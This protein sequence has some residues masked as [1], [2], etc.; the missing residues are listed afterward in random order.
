MRKLIFI[1]FVVVSIQLN[2]QELLPTKLNSGGSYFENTSGSLEVSVGEIYANLELK[3]GESLST[4][5]LQPLEKII[6]DAKCVNVNIITVMPNPV[7]NF[8]EIQSASI[9]I[10]K[11]EIIN[12][13]GNV[14][15]NQSFTNNLID[16]S[17][18]INGAYYLRLLDERN[19]LLKTFK[20]IKL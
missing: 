12:T 9:V 7:S 3:N 17:A 1:F 5:F 18:L 15:L 4:Y 10:N 8:L 13:S 20:F 11:F 2:A 16:V 14:V 19:A 6:L